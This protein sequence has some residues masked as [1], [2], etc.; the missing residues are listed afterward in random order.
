LARP[1]VRLSSIANDKAPVGCF[2]G[3]P[4]PGTTLSGRHVL[5]FHTAV[6]PPSLSG[7][8][9]AGT[10]SIHADPEDCDFTVGCEILPTVVDFAQRVVA[11]DV[12]ATHAHLA[13]G[14]DDGRRYWWSD[15]DS[16]SVL[17]YAYD[18]RSWPYTSDLIKN[19]S[20]ALQAYVRSL[21]WDPAQGYG[22]GL[23]ARSEA[24]K[25]YNQKW[26]RELRGEPET[27]QPLWWLPRERTFA[28]LGGWPIVLMEEPRPSDDVVCTVFA[29][30]EPR[31]HIF[32]NAKGEL[33]CLDDST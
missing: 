14:D 18:D 6:V 11:T 7:R 24:L 12:V 26:W 10:L 27:P 31:R 22:K 13:R 25:S 23:G 4:L 20:P 19:G 8:F 30:E 16:S 17:L 21:D 32:L 2:R 15:L 29:E 5:S 33:E 28:V 9:G 1:R 3:G